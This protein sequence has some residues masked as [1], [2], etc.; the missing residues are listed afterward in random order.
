MSQDSQ[1][2]LA[3]L[4]EVVT[5]TAAASVSTNL[6]FKPTEQEEEEEDKKKKAGFSLWDIFKSQ[7]ERS[8]KKKKKAAFWPPHSLICHP[9]E[10]GQ[11]CSYQA[12]CSAGNA[13]LCA[14]L[15]AA[16][17]SCRK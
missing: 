17:S 12:Q 14:R 5:G 16:Q 15:K 8:K 1:S 2:K 11:P 9:Q 4:G 10:T 13:I 7:Q 3:C 6:Y